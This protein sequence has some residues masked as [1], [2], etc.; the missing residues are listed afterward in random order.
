MKYSVIESA[1]SL[2][3]HFGAN[4]RWFDARRTWYVHSSGIWQPD[5][6][7]AIVRAAER[8]ASLM[9]DAAFALDEED[10]TRKHAI[11]WARKSADPR[12]IAATIEAA[13]A[14]VGITVSPE[15]W[16]PEPLMLAARNGIID[17]ASGTLRPLERRDMVTRQ[18]ACDYDAT[19]RSALW[20][21]FLATLT[22]GDAELAAWLQRSF[23]YALLGEWR[24]KA[25]WFGYGPPD[26]GKSLLLNVIGDVL[27]TYHVS[28]DA[29]TWMQRLSGGTRGDLTRL[30][31]A[32]LVTTSEV[33]HDA[34]FD[35]KIMKSVTGG[36]PIVADAKYEATIQF[37]PVFA[38][39]FAGNHR[40]QADASDDA[41]WVRAK[42]VPFTHSVPKAQQDP[43]LRAKLTS[44]EHGRGVL[45]WLVRGAQA[46]L[47]AGELGTC[48]AVRRA[49]EAYRH[50]VNPLA[51]FAEECLI[52]GGGEEKYES[53]AALR[54]EY[55]A[56]CSR[57]NVKMPL[58]Q[59]RFFVALRDI[60]VTVED[61]IATIA[62]QRSRVCRNVRIRR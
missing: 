50:D 46:Y 53:R 28:A 23:G 14:R 2:V 45:A 49:S 13:K 18:C 30:L 8:N 22:G 27:G 4:F 42:C 58:K 54:D 39:W 40:P 56:W 43:K 55:A 11:F 21:G 38:L 1:D 36:D 62:G 61:D 5:S 26:A 15:A 29:S 6:T 59:K 48:E 3:F 57:E 51:E 16:D 35:S 24:E 47:Q 34:K 9:L 32:R 52:V 19:A 33:A 44:P 41:F 12:I 37:S 7:R 31:G 17:L 20:D 10:A 25:F 60:G